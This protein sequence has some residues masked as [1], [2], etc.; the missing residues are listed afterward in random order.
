MGGPVCLSCDSE[1]FPMI[2]DEFKPDTFLCPKCGAWRRIE[3][4]PPA[5]DAMMGPGPRW[6]FAKSRWAARR[7]KALGMSFRP[8][9]KQ[10]WLRSA[11][12]DD[13]AQRGYVGW[14]PR[15]YLR[16]GRLERKFG[17]KTSSGVRAFRFPDNVPD[18]RFVP[19]SALPHVGPNN[20][21]AAVDA[22]GL[23]QT[24]LEA[25]ESA[26]EAM[27]W[28]GEFGVGGLLHYPGTKE[29]LRFVYALRP[30]FAEA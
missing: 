21:A 25:V 14:V 29:V 19:D 6:R 24:K 7:L 2:G 9:Y 4:F 5:Y 13:Y 3:P 23:A 11:A 8:G 17:I 20:I 18:V 30:E 12:E 16:G 15:S 10:F 28:P 22:V 1:V 26:R 27:A